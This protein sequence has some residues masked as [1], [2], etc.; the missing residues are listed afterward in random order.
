MRILSFVQSLQMHPVITAGVAFATDAMAAAATGE[1]G[2]D[3]TP[4]IVLAREPWQ[5][6][7]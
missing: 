7:R 3:A 4:R 6:L 5:M 2:P 1:V